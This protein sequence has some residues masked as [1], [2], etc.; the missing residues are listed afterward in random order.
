MMVVMMMMFLDVHDTGRDG[1]VG[2]EVGS[3]FDLIDTRSFSH[4]DHHR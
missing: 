3:K 2:V 1:S 4:S